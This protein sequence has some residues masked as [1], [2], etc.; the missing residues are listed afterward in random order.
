[1]MVISKLKE[2]LPHVRR[3]YSGVAVNVYKIEAEASQ[4]NQVPS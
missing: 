1:M 2:C 3:S 4:V